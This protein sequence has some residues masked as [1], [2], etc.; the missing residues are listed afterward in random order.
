[1]SCSRIIFGID[2]WVVEF[3]IMVFGGGEWCLIESDFGVFI[4]LIC[5]FGM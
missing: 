4:E 1:M 2:F 3:N 5:G